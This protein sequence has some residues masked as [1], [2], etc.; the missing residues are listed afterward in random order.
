[1]KDLQSFMHLRSR[2]F[3]KFGCL[4]A[5]DLVSRISSEESVTQRVGLETI[6]KDTVDILSTTS[7]SSMA[8][9]GSHPSQQVDTSL[10]YNMT[11][12]YQMENSHGAKIYAD[13]LGRSAVRIDDYEIEFCQ[14]VPVSVQGDRYIDPYA[15]MYFVVEDPM[16]YNHWGVK[17]EKN[18]GKD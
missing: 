8:S 4:S 12:E 6:V 11:L 15:T 2:N 1:M 9:Q 13:P 14:E 5:R 18:K 7:E 3:I 17:I 10:K 16:N